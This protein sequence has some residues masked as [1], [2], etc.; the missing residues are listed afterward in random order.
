MKTAFQDFD[1]AIEHF[2][3]EQ[4]NLSRRFLQ[5]CA[6]KL[7]P[8]DRLQFGELSGVKGT[9]WYSQQR[10][11]NAELALRMLGDFS[12]IIGNEEAAIKILRALEF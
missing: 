6:A 2:E 1:R 8:S 3:R 4:K 9:P 5:E 12:Q 7:G 10:L 11:Y